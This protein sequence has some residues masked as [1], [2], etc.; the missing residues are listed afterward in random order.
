[1]N[2]KPLVALNHFTVPTAITRTPL[3]PR[4][5]GRESI[6]GYQHSTQPAWW[7]LVHVQNTRLSSPAASVLGGHSRQSLGVL[8]WE[9]SSWA[10]DSQPSSRKVL[11]RSSLR[12]LRTRSTP[13]CPAAASP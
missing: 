11:S 10:T 13:G 1:M 5:L 7:R 8:T 6:D 3:A 12:M 4:T 2:P 9:R